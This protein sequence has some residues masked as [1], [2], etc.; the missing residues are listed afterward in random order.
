MNCI[1]IKNIHM[2]KIIIL[3]AFVSPFFFFNC[4]DNMDDLLINDSLTTSEVVAGLKTALEI[5]TDSSTNELSKENGFY[6]NALLKIVL[7]PEAQIIYDTKEQLKPYASQ[8]NIDL[9]QKLENLVV[10]INRAAEDASKEAKPIFFDAIKDLT[11][12]D[13]WSILNGIVPDSLKSAHEGFDSLAATKYLKNKTFDKLLTVFATPINNSLNKKIVFDISTNDAWKGLIDNYNQ[14][15]EVYNVAAALPFSTLEPL[16]PINNVE[17]GTYCTDKAL[18]GLFSKV[19][20]E[21][22]KIRDNPLD[23]SVAIIQK[24]FGYIADKQK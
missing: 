21:E 11:I 2:K 3:L 6:G 9:D 18:K 10:S 8:L 24:V 19:G 1:V 12:A 20:D 17:L 16:S 23:W 13:G 7:P 4:G 22:K 5:G 14:I 15:V